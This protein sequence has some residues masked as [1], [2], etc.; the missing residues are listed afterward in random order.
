MK[1]SI[2]IV[3][4]LICATTFGQVTLNDLPKPVARVLNNHYKKQEVVIKEV[5]AVKPG[6]QSYRFYAI[7]TGNPSVPEGYLHLGKVNT[8]RAGGCSGPE[9]PAA[10][11]L[12]GEYFDYLIIFN[13]ALAVETIQ[14][15]N[16]QA[17]YGHEIASRG[18]L[19]QF[20]GF[21]GEKS[22]EP[23]KDIDIISGA[24]VSVHAIT[25]DVQWKTK[26]LQQMIQ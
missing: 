10:S 5:E 23:G 18:W 22:L 7:Y 14:I 26:L 16:Y 11:D 4:L 20:Q 8:C 1:H 24:T 21:S 9:N 3:F 6:T 12:N 2:I 19:K 25:E 15:F 17:S 13:R